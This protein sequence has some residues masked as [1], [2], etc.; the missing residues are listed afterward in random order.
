MKTKT[1]YI[2]TAPV[3]L[4]DRKG[5]VKVLPVGHE[6]ATRAYGELTP[7]QRAKFTSVVKNV[8]RVRFNGGTVTDLP[9][10]D[11]VVKTVFTPGEFHLLPVM[12]HDLVNE[13]LPLWAS[14]C[15]DIPFPGVEVGEYLGDKHLTWWIFRE[16]LPVTA[17]PMLT[18][19]NRMCKPVAKRERRVGQYPWRTAALLKVAERLRSGRPV[20]S[21]SEDA[22]D[23]VMAA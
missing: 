20:F 17:T 1:V 21:S 10:V 23:R 13:V 2:S 19:A 8:G 6:L 18:T 5:N 11:G 12:V 14:A 15:P 7:N 9:V 4:T 16:G 22:I 3:Y